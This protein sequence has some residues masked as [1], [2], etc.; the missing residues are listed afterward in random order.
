MIL[1]IFVYLF[2]C[3]VTTIKVNFRFYKQCSQAE[4]RLICKQAIF[5][6]NASSFFS[7]NIPLYI[8]KKS[9]GKIM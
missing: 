1:A 8:E 6:Q 4:T 2:I 3:K 9:R 7:S 5:P